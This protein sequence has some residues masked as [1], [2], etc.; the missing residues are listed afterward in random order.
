M[1]LLVAEHLAAF[2]SCSQAAS[3][4]L[5]AK[6]FARNLILLHKVSLESCVQ[7]ARLRLAEAERAEEDRRAVDDFYS[8]WSIDSDGHWSDLGA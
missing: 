7:E 3:L 4:R 2:V 1:F 5:V 6:G 8:Q